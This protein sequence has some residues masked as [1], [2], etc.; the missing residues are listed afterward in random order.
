MDVELKDL[1]NLISY[2]QRIVKTD[3]KLS[4]E[5]FMRKELSYLFE[6][7]EYSVHS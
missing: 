7:V 3:K 6:D 1:Q 4:Y 2:R 5:D